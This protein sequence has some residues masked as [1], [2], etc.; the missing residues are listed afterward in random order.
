MIDIRSRPIRSESPGAPA[1]GDIRPFRRRFSLWAE[2]CFITSEPVA[3]QRSSWGAEALSSPVVFALS[4]TNRWPSRDTSYRLWTFSERKP[5]V[6]HS[7]RSAARE[8]RRRPRSERVQRSA[9][10]PQRSGDPLPP[11]SCAG[12]AMSGW[13]SGGFPGITEAADADSPAALENGCSIG[14]RLTMGKWRSQEW[15][16]TCPTADRIAAL[17]SYEPCRA[18][19]NGGVTR[20]VTC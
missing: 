19:L 20:E 3:G 5:N 12:V 16:A 18:A 4:M 2:E 15:S 6:E 11:D 10:F 9:H 17:G 13:T 8:G 1:R 7:H 14:F